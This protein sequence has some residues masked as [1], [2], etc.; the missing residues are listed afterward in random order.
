MYNEQPFFQLLNCFSNIGFEK[1]VFP[2]NFLKRGEHTKYFIRTSDFCYTLMSY[3][4]G[5]GFSQS[6]RCTGISW[7]A[8]DVINTHYNENV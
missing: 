6:S 2:L 5:N 4:G 7:K 3:R 8:W 1:Y